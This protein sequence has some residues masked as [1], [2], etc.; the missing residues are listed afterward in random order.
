[1]M[2]GERLFSLRNV[3]FT[4][5]VGALIGIVVV[6]AAIG[7]LWIPLAQSEKSA[8]G[9]WNAICTAA[10]VP[11]PYRRAQQAATPVAIPSDVI[12]TAQL[13]KPADGLSIGRGATLAMQCAGCHG[14]R[15]MSPA[16]APNLAGQ[17]DVATYKQ[18]RD[19]K[20]GHRGSAIMEPLAA[21]LGDQDMRDLAAYYGD[22]PREAGAAAA[23]AAPQEAPVIV[24]NGVPMRNIA[25]CTSC[26]GGIDGKTGSPRLD[27]Q[28]APY[29]QAQLQA[30]ASGARRNDIQ[31][32]M[33]NAARHMTPEEIAAAAR[34]YAGR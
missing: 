2:S 11:L 23:A 10:G 30:F 34:Y 8:A 22:L 27:G 1:M 26:H 14:A 3:W 17:H 20:S 9:L 21:S 24:R 12:V 25:A 13:M 7:F 19:F 32:Q 16:D 5:S 4:A 6:A 29:I 18:L 33:R 15:G 28:P 31:E